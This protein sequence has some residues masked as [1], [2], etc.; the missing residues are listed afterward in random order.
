[1]RDKGFDFAVRRRVRRSKLLPGFA[2]LGGR[3]RPP[4]RG[5]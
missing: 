1:M 2:P 5:L 4:L 3:G